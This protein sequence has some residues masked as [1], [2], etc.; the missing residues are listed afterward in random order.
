MPRKEKSKFDLEEKKFSLVL[1][2]EICGLKTQQTSIFSTK[3]NFFPQDQILNFLHEATQN[4]HCTKNFGC[5]G[6]CGYVP[7]SVKT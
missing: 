4:D 1:K 6:S 2:M 7:P 3:L 5:V